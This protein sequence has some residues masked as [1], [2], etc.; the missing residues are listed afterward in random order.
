[1]AKRTTQRLIAN[2]YALQATLGR[3]GMGVVWRAQDTL[4][5]REVAIKEVQ[6]PPSLSSAEL[7]SVRAR[8]LREA[9]AAARL[10]HPGAVTLY[11]VV[12]EEGHTF[13]VMELVEAPTLAHLVREQGPLPPDRVAAI[14]L[15]V[16][17]ALR[18]AHRVGIVHR[19]VK[20]GNVMV[21][22]RDGGAKLADFGI[23]SLAGDPQLTS[24]GL[25]LGSPAYMAP[26]QANGRPSGPPT[27]L[28]ALGATMYFAVEGEPPFERQGTIPTL[29]A[30]VHDPPRP[31]RRAGALAPVILALL[32]KSAAERPSAGQLQGQLERVV[33]AGQ[34]AT[35]S[36][37]TV[38]AAPVEPPPAEEEH[39]PTA[40]L[41]VV[42]PV[43][44]P[45]PGPAAAPA[46]PEDTD[47][48][49]P[50]VETAAAPPAPPQEAPPAPPQEAPPVEEEAPAGEEASP[51][52]AAP[53]VEESAPA[54]EEEAPAGEETAPAGEAAP[55]EAAPSARDEPAPPA[56]EAPPPTPTP[57]PAS[58]AQA[59]AR[60]LRPAP[61]WPAP[62]RP[63][64]VPGVAP[65]RSRRGLLLAAALLAVV[66]VLAVT[67]LPG[68]LNGGDGRQASP[69]SATSRA[70]GSRSGSGTTAAPSTTR[71]PGTT[72]AP[73]SAAPTTTAAGPSVPAGWRLSSHPDRG[74]ALAVPASWR[75]SQSGRQVNFRGPESDWGFF[76]QSKSPPNDL[77]QAGDVWEG[78]IRKQHGGDGLRMVSKGFGEYQGKQAYILE[79]TYQDG[80]RLVRERDVNV[81]MGR[82]G[83]SLVFHAPES[84]WGRVE[85]EVWSGVEQSLRTVG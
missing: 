44:P 3:G 73:T 6:L 18:A 8:V 47:D 38:E 27:D 59:P 74:F 66:G 80:G 13:I 60:D 35:A 7:A 16:L 53:A 76:I 9:R 31:M 58:P 32:A 49:P 48:S 46:A 54:V 1:M 63:A 26:E 67:L 2:R 30:V 28:W 36:Q 84:D 21:A 50:A 81:A 62:E 4:L 23:A 15:E 19:D 12:Q 78:H 14:G 17:D 55:V 10:N 41:P 39:E 70:A 40:R 71:P 24:T 29:T 82:W 65:G 37:P 22:S 68:A 11:D 56:V 79:Y 77:Q 45:G 43:P 20:P 25:V 42:V 83:F 34:E 5:A 85:R 75:V 61:A 69:P 51:V 57:T 72:A 52:E 64:P 33:A